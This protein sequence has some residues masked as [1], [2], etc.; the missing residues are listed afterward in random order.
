MNPQKYDKWLKWFDLIKEEVCNL[1]MYQQIFLDVQEI[2]NDNPDIQKPSAFYWFLSSSYA[3]SAAVAVRRLVKSH[4]DSITF[5]SLLEELA[6][7]AEMITVEWFESLYEG[8]DV[9]PFARDAF[10]D[11]SD[12]S[13]SKLD[14]EKVRLDIETLKKTAATIEDFADK[15]IA[16]LD[17]KKPDKIPT[18]N[19]LNECIAKIDKLLCKYQLL[20]KAVSSDSMNPTIIDHW[21]EVFEYPW[22]KK[23][24]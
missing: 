19:D 13:N 4:K 21:K 24:S 5:T 23:E 16:H 22:I 17:K 20:L 8:S 7:N 11:F 3:A 18:F 9:A 6:Q 10:E 15:T 2:I 14:S 12:P 1:C